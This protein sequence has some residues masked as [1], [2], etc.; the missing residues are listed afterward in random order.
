MMHSWRVSTGAAETVVEAD[1]WLAALSAAM[2]AL[3]LP[4]GALPRLAVTPQPDG[5]AVAR[6]PS[7]GVEVRIAPLG[8][9]SG[10]RPLASLD[11]EDQDFASEEVP[12]VRLDD[13]TLEDLFL[14]LADLSSA[15]DVQRASSAALRVALQYVEA[16]AG[17]VL[18]RTRAGDGLRFRAASGPAAGKLIDTVIPLAQGIAGQVTRMG[19]GLLVEDVR[20]DRRHNAQIDRKT[21]F[22]TQEMI[23]VPVRM[24]SGAACGVLELL[25]PPRPF[26]ARDFEIAAH[27]G[28]SLGSVLSDA[29]DG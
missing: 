14:R 26:T 10:H 12:H 8:D 4:T 24:R 23:A 20:A 25:N 7:T 17:C 19:I 15:P 22:T 3:Q 28:A 11:A 9:V 13:D 1:H 5:G 21:G 18:I 2:P 6:E 16:K 29:Y 27:V